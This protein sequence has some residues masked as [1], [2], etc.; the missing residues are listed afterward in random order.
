MGNKVTL[1]RL[2]DVHESK[3]R[4]NMTYYISVNLLNVLIYGTTL[5]HTCHKHSTRIN[6]YGKNITR[7][8]STMLRFR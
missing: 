7:E 6:V 3:Q 5:K 4:K 2:W 1:N 8:Q